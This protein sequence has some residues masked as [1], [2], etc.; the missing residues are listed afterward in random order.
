MPARTCAADPTRTRSDG[1]DIVGDD[2]SNE[3]DHANR[4]PTG[5]LS[6][7]VDRGDDLLVES[8][9]SDEERQDPVGEFT[10]GA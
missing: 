2:R 8:A 3:R 1:L 9:W 7:V 5:V 4:W 10:A 6:G